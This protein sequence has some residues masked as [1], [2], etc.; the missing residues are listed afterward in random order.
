MIKIYCFII[1]LLYIKA[2]LKTKRPFKNKCR[3]VIFI[4]FGQVWRSD[5]CCQ[6]IQFIYSIFR[7][8]DSSEKRKQLCCFNEDIHIFLQIFPSELWK[9]FYGNFQRIQSL[10]FASLDRG[11]FPS[12]PFSFEYC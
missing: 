11:I 6:I 8:E 9:R 10:T 12:H 1:E 3:N 7:R 4:N 2:T 5:S